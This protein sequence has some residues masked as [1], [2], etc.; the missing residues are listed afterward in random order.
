MPT[1]SAS[2]LSRCKV[3]E[4]LFYFRFLRAV[5][6]ITVF[7][8]LGPL[9]WTIHTVTD[10]IF[11]EHVPQL[12]VESLE[13]LAD[14]WIQEKFKNRF[15]AFAFAKSWRKRLLEKPSNLLFQAFLARIAS[16]CDSH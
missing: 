15:R 11:C 9:R 4:L 14:I 5:L 12:R 7:C 16:R 8:L 2:S 1:P 3:K 10:S 6:I 13:D